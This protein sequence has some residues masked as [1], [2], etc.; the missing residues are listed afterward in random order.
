MDVLTP[1]TLDEACRLKAE[2]PD[3]RF[4]QGGT[5]VLVELNFDRSRPPALIN[6]N[7]VPELRGWRDEDGTLVLGAGLTY[8]EAMQAPLAQRLPAL[9]EASRTVGSPQIRNRGTLGGNLGTASPA[10]DSLPPLLVAATLG[11]GGERPRQAPR[12]AR[13]VPGRPEAERARARRARGLPARHARRR[14]ARRS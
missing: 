3:G 11:R 6:L 2:L 9:A 7:E 13:R 4:V 10:G 1:R 5:D 12:G 8:T 14:R